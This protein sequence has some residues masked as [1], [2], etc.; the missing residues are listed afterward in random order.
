MKEKK[1]TDSGFDLTTIKFGSQRVNHVDT[2]SDA[3]LT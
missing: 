1:I 2:V 3:K